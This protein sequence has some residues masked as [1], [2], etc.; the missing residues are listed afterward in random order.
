MKYHLPPGCNTSDIP[1][2]RPEDTDFVGGQ[3]I[4][5]RITL[6]EG[7]ICYVYHDGW[8]HVEMENGELRHYEPSDVKPA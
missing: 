8:L 4:K 6:E 5:D 1:G 3:K 2:N 7:T